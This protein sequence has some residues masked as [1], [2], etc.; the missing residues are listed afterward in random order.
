MIFSLTFSYV[1]SHRPAELVYTIELPRV[2]KPS[3]VQLDVSER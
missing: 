2:T 3:K 1:L